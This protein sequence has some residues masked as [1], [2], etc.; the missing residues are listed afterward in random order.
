[1]RDPQLSASRC[2]SHAS[3]ARDDPVD[4][5]DATKG[6]AASYPAT[7]EN[8]RKRARIPQTTDYSVS[9][10]IPEGLPIT[11]TEL[12]ALEILLGTDLKELL[13]DAL[14]EFLK[15]SRLNR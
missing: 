5:I 4:R 1:V 13:A 10:A 3:P 7:V 11:E 14:F 12:R 8:A 15:S 6:V 2:S 9:I